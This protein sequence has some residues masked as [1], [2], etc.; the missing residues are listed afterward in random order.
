MADR[1]GHDHGIVHAGVTLTVE[2]ADTTYRWIHDGERLGTE[3]PCTAAKPIARFK[4]CKP[5]PARRTPR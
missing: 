4:V 5:E 3:V 2:A 1:G